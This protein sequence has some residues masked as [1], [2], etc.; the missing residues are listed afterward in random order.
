VVA[1]GHVAPSRRSRSTACPCA[2]STSRRPGRTSCGASST[3][4][5]AFTHAVDDHLTHRPRAG[6][7]R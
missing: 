4:G 6:R 1:E 3:G 2:D 7:R 5:G